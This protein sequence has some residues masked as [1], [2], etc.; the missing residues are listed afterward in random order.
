[1]E[2]KIEYIVRYDDGQRLATIYCID[3]YN[4]K[5]LVDTLER[6]DIIYMVVKVKDT[7]NHKLKWLT[8]CEELFEEV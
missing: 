5:D 3:E 8:D 7:D 6:Q 1:M 4:M 2:K